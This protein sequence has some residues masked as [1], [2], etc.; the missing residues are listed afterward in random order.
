MD[1]FD[2]IDFTDIATLIEPRRK[3]LP[4]KNSPAQLGMPQF[5]DTATPK[6][7]VRF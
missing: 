4:E 6:T 1:F 2:R 7:A 3:E 5:G